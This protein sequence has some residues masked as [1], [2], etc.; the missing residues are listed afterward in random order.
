MKIL[1]LHRSKSNNRFSFEELFTTIRKYLL[2]VDISDF[3]DKT[4]SSFYKNINEVKKIKTDIIHITGGVGYYALFLNSN[5][6]VLTIHDLNH[7]EFD[8]KGIK[9][10]IFSLVYYKL[11]I[12]NVKFVTVV[13]DHT[14]NKLIE[15]FNTPENKIKVIPNCYDEEFIFSPKPELNNIPKILHLGTKQNKNLPNLILSLKDI[16]CE[17]TIIG[18]LSN[19]Q[20]NLLIENQI[21]Y[22]NKFNLTRKEIYNEYVN[23]DIVSFI[24]LREGFGLPIIEANAVGRAIITSNISS[25][26]EVAG[27]SAILVDPTNIN[28]IKDGFLKLIHD[29]KYRNKLI[30]EGLENISRFSP[31]RIGKLYSNLYQTIINANY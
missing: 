5:K 15:L 17:L 10:W 8:L 6:T 12:K 1:F 28:Q 16:P 30:E 2:N 14:K 31:H 23:T 7:Y 19:E 20:S 24:S 26:P 4:Y 22:I 11:P 18:R 9:K 13:S 3:Y 25:M 21:N 27:N 29:D